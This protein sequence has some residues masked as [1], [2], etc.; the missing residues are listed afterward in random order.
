MEPVKYSLADW[1]KE[2]AFYLTK[3]GITKPVRG[4]PSNSLEGELQR[5][6][7]RRLVTS[8]PKDVR[9]DKF[10][11]W[12]RFQDKKGRCKIPHYTGTTF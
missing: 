10:G 8:T 9:L 7:R 3:S 12:A 1:R 6:K 2:I 4:R 5:V 11:H